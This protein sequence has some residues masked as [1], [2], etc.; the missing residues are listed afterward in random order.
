[1]RKTRQE[2]VN[3]FKDAFLEGRSDAFKAKF[4]SRDLSHQYINIMSWRRRQ[5]EGPSPRKI[6]AEEKG[7]M[8]FIKSL[9]KL[10]KALEKGYTLSDVE[11]RKA[12]K[13]L[14]FMREALSNYANIQRD[15]QIKAL[16]QKGREIAEQLA[17]LKGE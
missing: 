3:E 17:A 5:E 11:I 8:D 4:E 16:E 2:T 15:L 10:R 12:G 9:R 6:A 13:E 7:Q 14:N 1:M